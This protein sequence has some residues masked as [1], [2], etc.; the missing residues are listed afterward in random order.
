MPDRNAPYLVGNE[1]GLKTLCSLMCW[2]E[3]VGMGGRPVRH[4]R[5]TGSEVVG[6]PCVS[7][8]PA[9]LFSK[10]LVLV[11]ESLLGAGS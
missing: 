11:L 8:T 3:M 6:V 1:V 4:W 7:T 2:R 10:D 9:T 5:A